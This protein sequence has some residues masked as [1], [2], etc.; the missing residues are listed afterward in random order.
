[1]E[2]FPQLV[3]LS[4][5]NAALGQRGMKKYDVGHYRCPQNAGGK[6]DALPAREP[7]NEGRLYYPHSIGPDKKQFDQVA[8]RHHAYHQCDHGLYRTKT[9]SLEPENQESDDCGKQSSPHQRNMKEQKQP[10]GGPDKLGQIGGDRDHF[11]NDPHDPYDRTG[12]ILPAQFREVPSRGDA[13][14]CRQNL[15]EHGNKIA[16]YYHPEKGVSELGAALNIGREVTRID[17]GNG[18]DESR[19]QKR[20]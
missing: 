17:I 10:D 6:H 16:Y 14:L 15:D 9:V 20:Q 7:W 11:H 13:E 8:G 1:M 5:H 18:G 4:D 12:K 2:Q 19:A 3:G